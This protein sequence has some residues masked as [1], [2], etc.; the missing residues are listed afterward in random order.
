MP[1]DDFYQP[2][3]VGHALDNTELG[4]QSDDTGQNISD[5]NRSWCELTG[6]Y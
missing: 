3:H 2:L 5:K 1:V 6:I 4:Y